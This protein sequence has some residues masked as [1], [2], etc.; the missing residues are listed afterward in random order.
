[1]SAIVD[2]V[3]VTLDKT[4]ARAGGRRHGQG[5]LPG[6]W[7]GAA[8][9]ARRP[10]APRDGHAD[11]RSRPTRSTRWRW[12][13]ASRSSTSTRSRASSTPR[14]VTDGDLAPHRLAHADGRARA[15]VGHARRGRPARR[16]RSSATCARGRRPSSARS[17]APSTRS[18][19]RSATPGTASPTTRT[20]SA[21]TTSL[22]SPVAEE[23]PTRPSR[24][25]RRRAPARRPV[26]WSLDLP[27]AGDVPEV[28]PGW[29]RRRARTSRTPSRSTRAATTGSSVGMP[30]ATG[31][32]LVGRIDQVTA[33]VGHGRARDRPRVPGGGAAGHHGRPRHRP[34]PGPRRV[35]HGR[36]VDL[37][38]GPRSSSGHRRGH[39]RR[40]PQRVPA[41]DPGGHGVV[42]SRQGSGGLSLELDVDPLVDFDQLSYVTVLQWQPT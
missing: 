16:A 31:A 28:W 26:R 35:A 5:H 37:A 15:G 4:P 11:R 25:V 18:R 12:G 17:R 13:R 30:V 29:C 6:R 23:E 8:Q 21:R 33:H 20:S 22:R 34:R 10:A 7:R 39:E 42:D 2:A 3:K 14:P 1:M 36:L 38:P 41:R 24:A 9:R 32:G 40:R 27:F 19:A